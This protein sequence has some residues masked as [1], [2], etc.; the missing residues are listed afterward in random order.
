MPKRLSTTPGMTAAPDTEATSRQPDDADRQDDIKRWWRKETIFQH[1]CTCGRILQWIWPDTRSWIPDFTSMSRKK[2]RHPNTPESRTSAAAVTN[3]RNDC[4]PRC[5]GHGLHSVPSQKVTKFF[6]VP[7]LSFL[8]Q[9]TWSFLGPKIFFHKGY[10]VLNTH[11]TSYTKDFN[12]M[13]IRRLKVNIWGFL[14]QGFSN[15][16]E[17]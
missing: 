8:G 15:S 3:S 2:V 4:G 7:N 1:F 5:R 9:P 11:Y 12:F 10:F 14:T 17:F 13:K 6:F 16:W